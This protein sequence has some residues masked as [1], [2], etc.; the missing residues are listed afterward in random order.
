MGN[1]RRWGDRPFPWGSSS[2]SPGCANIANY[3]SPMQARDNGQSEDP[4]ALEIEA[5]IDGKLVRLEFGNPVKW[6]IS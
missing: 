2:T 1:I 4:V 6:I 5:L 3:P